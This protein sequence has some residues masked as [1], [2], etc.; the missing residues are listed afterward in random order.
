MDAVFH[1]FG[2]LIESIT[3][4]IHLPLMKRASSYSR[5]VIRLN[6]KSFTFRFV[7]NPISTS[8]KK[9]KKSKT[10]IFTLAKITIPAF[11]KA[12]SSELSITY[13]L[14]RKSY[15]ISRNRNKEMKLNHRR[16]KRIETNGNN[17]KQ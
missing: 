16:P 1:L 13:L 12:C 6:L 8:I 11:L 10:N 9:E 5:W 3:K 14:G 4:T 15:I 7:E 17:L 2:Q